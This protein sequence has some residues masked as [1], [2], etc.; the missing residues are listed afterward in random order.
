MNEKVDMDDPAIR[1][2]VIAWLRLHGWK[3][4]PA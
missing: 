4:E 1:L 2:E 3:V